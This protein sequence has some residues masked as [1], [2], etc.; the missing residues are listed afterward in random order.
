MSLRAAGLT[1]LVCATACKT[2]HAV[3]ANAAQTVSIQGSD[4]MLVLMEKWAEA[5]RNAH[6]DVRVQ[7]SGGGSGAGLASLIRRGCDVAAASRKIKPSEKDQLE[8]LHQSPVIEIPVAIDAVSLYVHVNNPIG[9]LDL[10]TL[11]KMYQNKIRWWSDLGGKTQRIVL[12]SRENSSGT[13][14]FFKEKVL[15]DEDFAEDVQTLPGTAAVIQAVSQD[16]KSIGYGGMTLSKS[17]KVLGIRLPSGVV[18]YP[19]TKALDSNQDQAYPLSRTLFL[20]TTVQQKQRPAI[21]TFIEW[22]Q[23]SQGQQW[24][25]QAGFGPLS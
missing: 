21:R 2:S 1:F 4:T 16:P 5:Y 9:A 6:P 8:T 15:N 7:L 24:V 13:Y 25:R 20:Y 10:E 22:I 12:Y 19:S 11:K 17:T 23:S 14:A 3:R 18:R